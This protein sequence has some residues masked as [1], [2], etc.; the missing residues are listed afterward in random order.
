MIMIFPKRLRLLA[1][2]AAITLYR[3]PRW[4]V[5]AQTGCHQPG[6]EKTPRWV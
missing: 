1:D 2:S 4:S 6:N 3:S 5:Y